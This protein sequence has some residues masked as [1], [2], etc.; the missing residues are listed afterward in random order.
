M[1]IDLGIIAYDLLEDCQGVSHVHV[2]P[3][4]KASSKASGH[5]FV[6]LE[7]DTSELIILEM[8]CFRWIYI[9][10]LQKAGGRRSNSFLLV[11]R[12]VSIPTSKLTEQLS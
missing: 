11:C 9:P 5:E 7:H 4:F 10:L 2:V 3:R 1:E 6:P 12:F 8:D